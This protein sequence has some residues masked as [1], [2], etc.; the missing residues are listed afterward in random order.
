MGSGWAWKWAAL[1][2]FGSQFRQS[3]P[4]LCSVSTVS[5]LRGLAKQDFKHRPN[6]VFQALP[7]MKGIAW[8]HQQPREGQG[9]GKANT[10]ATE[11]N[12]AAPPQRDVKADMGTSAAVPRGTRPYHN[13][14][15]QTQTYKCLSRCFCSH[16]HLHLQTGHSVH[17]MAVVCPWLAEWIDCKSGNLLSYRTEKSKLCRTSLHIHRSLPQEGCSWMLSTG[18]QTNA[19]LCTM[20]AMR[21]WI[22]PPDNNPYRNW[23]FSHWKCP[24]LNSHELLE[25]LN[26]TSL[27]HHPPSS[28][29]KANLYFKAL[30]WMPLTCIQAKKN[31][32]WPCKSITNE[33]KKS[34]LLKDWPRSDTHKESEVSMQQLRKLGSRQPVSQIISQLY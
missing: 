25:V 34:H 10:K 20:N 2:L 18:V 22:P 30:C 12:T 8:L 6:V 1:F 21:S 19:Q 32:I 24:R 7:L 14:T 13:S 17:Y 9:K 31:A 15:T 23:F 28:S 16:I 26:L 29:N 4:M 3:T 11:A 33:E 27:W 5:L